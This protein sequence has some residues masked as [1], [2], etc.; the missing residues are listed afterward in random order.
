MKVI[1][2]C[3]IKGN[4]ESII[5]YGLKLAKK[6]QAKVEIIHTIDSRIQQ[7]VQSSYAD[8]QSITPGNK[9][10]HKDI[11]QREKNTVNQALNKLLS[12][13]ASMLNYPLKI[14]TIIEEDTIY[15]CLNKSIDEGVDNIVLVNSEPD[16]YIF[17]SRN[18]ILETLQKVNSLILLIPPKTSFKE[19]KEVLVIN[20]FNASHGFDE[21]IKINTFLNQFNPLINVVDVAKPKKFVEK[22]LKS[23]AWLQ[24]AGKTIFSSTVK[25]NILSGNDY[26]ETLNNYIGRTKPEIIM[27]IKQK[28]RL[29]RGNSQKKLLTYLINSNKLPILY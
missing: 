20:D 21:L 4:T 23:K 13:E 19:I 3:D 24:I 26:F 7:G 10:S 12:K 27:P 14:N 28:T 15:E 9:L 22:E 8:S 6:L 1:I 18:E 11:M 2:I 29:L 5:P 16:N 17:Q 25:T